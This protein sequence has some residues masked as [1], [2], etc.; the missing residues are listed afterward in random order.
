MPVG[1]FTFP[2]R[3]L[4]VQWMGYGAMQLVG[5]GVCGSP[6]DPE[7]IVRVPSEAIAAGVNHI[8]T[9]DFYGPHVTNQI[10]RDGF[11]GHLEKSAK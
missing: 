1:R 10:V 4:T 5:P 8:D 2:R 7:G 3:S 11:A 6:K 9:S